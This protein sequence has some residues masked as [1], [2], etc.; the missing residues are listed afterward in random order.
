MKRFLRLVRKDLEASKFPTGLLS[1]IIFGLMVFIR[2]KIG[3]YYL[4][5]H[6]HMIAMLIIGLPLIFLPLWLFWQSFQSLR[7]EWRED[8]VYTLLVLPVPG[9]QVMLSKLLGIWAEYTVLLLVSLGSGLLLFWSTIKPLWQVLP[10][11]SWILWNGFLLYL[12]SLGILTTFV[13]FMQLGFIAGKMVGRVQG[14]VAIWVWVLSSW[15]VSRIGGFLEPLFRWIPPIPLHRIGQLELLGQDI[16]LD[17]NISSQLGSFL[18]L[19]ALFW[20]T[21]YLFEH[22][23]EING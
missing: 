18:C 1:G 17:W 19:V 12:V 15:L 7:S 10:S 14:L 13:I 5:P 8:T 9:W 4:G 3:D 21:S 6:E 22:F 23:V 16:L 20:L 2:Y 11:T